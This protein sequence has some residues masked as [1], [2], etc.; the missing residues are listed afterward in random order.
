MSREYTLII[1]TAPAEARED[2]YND[3]HASIRPSDQPGTLVLVASRR[4]RVRVT[5]VPDLAVV[6]LAAKLRALLL[7]RL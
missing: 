1:N 4:E 5:R 7:E 3:W 2:D 6:D